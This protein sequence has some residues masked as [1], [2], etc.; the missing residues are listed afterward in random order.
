VEGLTIGGVTP[1]STLDFPDALAAVIYCQ[2]CP[3]GCP[4]CH[5][6]PLREITDQGQR[7]SASVLAWLEGRRGLLDA[8]VFSG[9]EPTLQ[10]GLAETMTAVR[11]LGFKAGLHTTGMF[12]D[13]LAGVLPLC[14]WVGLDVKAPRA[15][16]PRITGVDGSGEAA[17]ASLA[18]LLA[19]GLPF[20]IRTTWHPGLLDEAELVALAGELAAADAGR[21]VIQAFRPDGCADQALADAGPTVFPPD[22][23]SRLQAVAPRLGIATRM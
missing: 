6:A 1:L 17:F 19:C 15:A 5:N 12:P 18:M 14:D 13:A 2:G 9:G 20:E 3:W 10:E 4:Y 23:V 21:W 11:A 8:V 16:Y 22:L 7:D